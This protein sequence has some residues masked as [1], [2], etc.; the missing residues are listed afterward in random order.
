MTVEP[1][2]LCVCLKF[3]L[4]RGK[5][6]MGLNG[7]SSRW[8]SAEG[9]VEREWGVVA[10]VCGE[11]LWVRCRRVALKLEFGWGVLLNIN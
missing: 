10:G 1:R 2:E 7:G 8:D 9:R 11:G 6:G 3:F 5:G 4:A